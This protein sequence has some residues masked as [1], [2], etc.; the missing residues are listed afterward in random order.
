MEK[1]A[2]G[3][4]MSALGMFLAADIV[5]Q[6][7]MVGLL[8]ASFV[9]WAILVAKSLELGAAKRAV[10]GALAELRRAPTLL[11]VKPASQTGV[12]AEM[13]REASG[14][15][16]FSRGGDKAGA[17]ERIAS[18]LERLTAAEARRISRAIN[19]IASIGATAPFVGLFGTV[20]GIMN[21]FIGISNAHTTSLAVVAPGIAEALLAT[22]CGL[23]VAIPA[24]VIYNH[25]SRA[26]GGYRALVADAAAAIHR[27][28]S[29]ELDN[30]A[31]AARFAAE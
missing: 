1:A 26:I 16:E 5:V 10:Q 19:I 12:A 3:A 8:F 4:D 21:S 27:L 14:E 15:L 25:F 17:K 6:A 28:A 2:A 23:V 7:V 11:A 18:H 31:H 20:W 9:V 29:R 22:A 24:V 30:T 13:V